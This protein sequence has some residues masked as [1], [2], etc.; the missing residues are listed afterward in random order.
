MLLEMPE[1]QIIMLIE[2]QLA[3]QD[4]VH[5]IVLLQLPVLCL[6]S[7]HVA[8]CTL[9]PGKRQAVCMSVCL[10][11]C[12]FVCARTEALHCTYHT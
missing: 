6:L 5:T 3:C 4:K 2:D 8:P 1:N 10:S 7:L 11:V 12:L 9:S